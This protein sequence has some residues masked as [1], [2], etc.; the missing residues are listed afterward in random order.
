MKDC[1]RRIYRSFFMITTFTLLM[2]ALFTSIF[3]PG[4]NFSNALLWQVLIFS[5]LASMLG[6]LFY[7][8]KELSTKQMLLL[9]LIHLILLVALLFTMAL[10]FHWITLG[11][12]TE[13]I[14]FLFMIIF[15]Y[16]IVWTSCYRADKNEA[17]K[18]NESLKNFQ[19]R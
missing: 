3:C 18:I 9:Q 10:L 4:D 11:A 6:L 7:S 16:I 19:S 13:G 2:T 1:L 17:M 5:L 8:K 15:V 12:V 14:T